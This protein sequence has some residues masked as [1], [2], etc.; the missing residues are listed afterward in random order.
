MSEKIKE[1]SPKQRIGGQTV[2]TIKTFKT[3][4]RL[5]EYANKIGYS[6]DTKEMTKEVAKNSLIKYGSVLMLFDP[7]GLID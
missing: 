3:I 1:L 2:K 6:K 5:V 7:Y 4:E